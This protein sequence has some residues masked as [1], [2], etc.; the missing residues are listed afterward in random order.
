CEYAFMEV[1]S[2]AIEQNRI[3]GLHFVGGI[4]TNI[5]HDHLDYHKTFKNYIKAKKKFFDD[6]PK[7][8]FALVNADD[9]NGAVM[10]QNTAASV[11]TFALKKPAAFKAKILENSLQGLHLQLDGLEMHT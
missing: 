1:S 8:A 6:L 11:H 7:G 3:A 5:T 9:K 4:F 10:V 2:H